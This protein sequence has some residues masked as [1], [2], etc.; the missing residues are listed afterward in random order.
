MTTSSCASGI[1][2]TV[3]G[4]QRQVKAE[5]AAAGG[6]VDILAMVASNTQSRLGFRD[7]SHEE[8]RVTCTATRNRIGRRVSKRKQEETSTINMVHAIDELLKKEGT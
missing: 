4:L 2:T 3:R 8:V 7:L 1:S 6:V 5:L